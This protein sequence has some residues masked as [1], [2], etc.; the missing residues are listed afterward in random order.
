VTLA[1]NGTLTISGLNAEAIVTLLGGQAVPFSE[2]SA[3]HASLEDAYLRLTRDA[4][5]Y[6]AKPD[7]EATR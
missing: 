1:G 2:V 3:H 4:V 7:T 6:R 5:E